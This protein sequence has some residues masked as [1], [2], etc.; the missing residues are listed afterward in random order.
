MEKYTI[1]RMQSI[2]TQTLPSSLSLPLP[3][4]PPIGI[5]IIVRILL[6]DKAKG[7]FKNYKVAL[8]SNKE[9]NYLC[10]NLTNAGVNYTLVS[11][12]KIISNVVN[13]SVIMLDFANNDV[14]PD[15]I[16]E[17]AVKKLTNPLSKPETKKLSKINKIHAEC[18]NRK[19]ILVASK[20]NILK[21][22]VTK[23]TF[24][25]TDYY[26][27]HNSSNKEYYCVINL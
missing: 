13:Y 22:I 9:C 2:A 15:N 27:D 12:D 6:K 4:S 19:L 3:L 26:I 7:A 20:K 16:I 18:S 5:P 14:M 10:T 8:V 11:H 1:Q 21:Q 23:Y 24:T 25:C 17:L